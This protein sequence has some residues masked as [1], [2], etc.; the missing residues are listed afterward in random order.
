M[1]IKAKSH[2]KHNNIKI[3]SQKKKNA[4][5]RNTP[6]HDRNT[7][8]RPKHPKIFTDTFQWYFVYQVEY[9]NGIFQVFRPE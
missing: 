7:L 8:K 6:K 5:S 9:R 3:Y 2:L 4:H 1:N